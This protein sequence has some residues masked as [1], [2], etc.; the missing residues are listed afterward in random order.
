MGGGGG[1][2]ILE[3]PVWVGGGG[4]GW[5]HMMLMVPLTDR[6][7]AVLVPIA[8]TCKMYYLFFTSCSSISTAFL[9]L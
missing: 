2:L 8:V 1:V 3:G 7:G 4:A 5:R 9:L 6:S